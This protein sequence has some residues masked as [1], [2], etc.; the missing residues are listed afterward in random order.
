MSK[1]SRRS[2]VT[3]GILSGLVAP[4]YKL[5]S[6]S[7]STAHHP[8]P[9]EI[10]G[11][12]YPLTPQKDKD[13]DLTQIEGVNG[14]AQGRII[15]I[16]GQVLD[17]EGDPV[18]DVTV[19]LWQANAAGRYRHPHDSNPAPLDPNFQGWA[20]VQSGKQGRFHF[21]TVLPGAYPASRTWMRPPHIH[22]KVSKRGYDE[23]VTQMYFEGQELNENDLL[24]MRKSDAEK[25]RMIAKRIKDQPET[26]RYT[27]ILQ[28]L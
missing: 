13:F 27:I 11:P 16:D 19:D 25:Q 9:T 4:F 8:T 28:A 3:V 14:T 12:F 22:F 17:T 18:E 21:K 23:L 2:F 5:V 10:E 20:I 6:A 24:L 7:D 15:H 26:Y 1:S